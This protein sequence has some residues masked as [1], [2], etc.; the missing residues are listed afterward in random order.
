[1]AEAFKKINDSA[2]LNQTFKLKFYFMPNRR[3]FIKQSSLAGAGL[4]LADSLVNDLYA[5]TRNF[6]N[7]QGSLRYR[8]VHLDFHNSE[9][10]EDMA[11]DFNPEEFAA[12]LK[13]ANVNSVTAFG[14]CHH[15]YIYHDTKF[16]E[17]KHP[18]LKRNLLK[19]QIQACH[20]IGIR[21]PVYVTV[22]WDHYTALHHPEWLVRDEN[23]TP[24]AYAS[25]NVWTLHHPI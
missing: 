6:E 14:R 18:F 24:I 13:K 10:F 9:L 5:N 21:V 20:K 23:G 8:Q 4:F 15:G 25:T 16:T 19:E 7:S 1:L 17:R 11:R 2:F 22:Q 3:N 12:T